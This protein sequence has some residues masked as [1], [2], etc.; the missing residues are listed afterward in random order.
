MIPLLVVKLQV[1]MDTEWYNNNCIQRKHHLR[2]FRVSIQ[3]MRFLKLIE[4]FENLGPSS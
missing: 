4:C 3:Q 2:S 1:K